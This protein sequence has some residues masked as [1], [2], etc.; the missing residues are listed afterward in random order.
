MTGDSNER[1][2]FRFNPLWWIDA[3]T[4]AVEAF[5]ALVFLTFAVLL[6]WPGDTLPNFV[7]YRIMSSLLPE[8]VWGGIFLGQWALQSLA[9]CGNV[10]LLRFPAA[11]CGFLLWAFIAAAYLL[12]STAGLGGY[13]FGWIAIF[14]AWVVWKGPTDGE[15]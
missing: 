7:A 5:S 10:R 8:T 6:L 3:D 14:M 15:R 13:L 4:R 1:R 12:S 11:L 2:V 9:M